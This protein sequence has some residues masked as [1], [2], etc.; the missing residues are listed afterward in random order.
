MYF[1]ER[2]LVNHTLDCFMFHH[3]IYSRY[4]VL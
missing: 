4:D 2:R 3:Y 1:I